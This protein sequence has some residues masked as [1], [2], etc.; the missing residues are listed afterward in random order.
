MDKP[1]I[2]VAMIVCNAA[3]FLNAAVDSILAQSCGDF[4]LIVVDFGSTDDSLSILQQ[5]AAKDRRVK[6]HKISKCSLAQA[7]NKSC[8]LAQGRYLAIMD[9]DDVSLVDRLKVEVEFMEQH[10]G[11]GLVGGGTEW[12][13]AEGRILCSNR[14]HAEHDEVRSMLSSTNPFCQSSILMSREAF[15]AVG[16]YRCAFAQAEDYDLWL[17]IADCF[18]CIMLD[19]ILVQY[20]IHAYQISSRGRRQQSLCAI[21]AQIA[22]DCR[23]SGRPDPFECV[24][25]ITPDLLA[26]HG[27]SKERQKRMLVREHLQWAKNMYR[28]DEGSAALNLAREVFLSSDWRHADR[29]VVADL[30]LLIAQVYWKQ[31]RLRKSV[32]ALGR[33]VVIRPVVACRP[34]KQLLRRYRPALRGSAHSDAR[35][36]EAVQ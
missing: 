4:E 5:Y 28:A 32:C 33:A 21:A 3:R 10:P 7:R 27:I 16:G 19:Q 29:W 31:K 18:P 26:T 6:I 11:T 14:F 15:T 17:R 25:E 24:A 1:L 36:A 30:Q 35:R 23:K 9:A 20:R 8:S 12:I 34:V 22:A 2:S 13:N